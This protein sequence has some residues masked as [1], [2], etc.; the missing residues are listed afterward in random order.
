MAWKV[1]FSS[2][3]QKNLEALGT[4]LAQRVLAF[5]HKRLAPLDNPRSLGEPLKGHRLGTLWKWRVDKLHLIASI[6]EDK[7]LVLLVHMGHRRKVYRR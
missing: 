1:E 3:A 4:P 5:L 6:E 7:L 2:L